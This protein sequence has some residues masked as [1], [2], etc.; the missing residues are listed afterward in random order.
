MPGSTVTLTEASS[1]ITDMSTSSDGSVLVTGSTDKGVRVYTSSGGN[2][3]FH[4][5]I[6]MSMII[7]KVHVSNDKSKIFVGGETDKIFI[8]GE[9]SGTYSLTSQ[10][11]LNSLVRIEQMAVSSDY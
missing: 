5:S 2:Y 3:A 7:N 11:Q 9:N 10:I 6:T 4:Q 1:E 8:L